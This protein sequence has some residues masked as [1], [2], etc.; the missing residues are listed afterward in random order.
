R[1]R[2]GR[3]EDRLGKKKQMNRL[4]EGNSSRNLEKCA[5]LERCGVRESEGVSVPHD[6]PEVRLGELRLRR[7]QHAQASDPNAV[8]R[9]RGELRREA[10]VDENELL[11]LPRRFDPPRAF[12]RRFEERYL[13]DRGDVRVLPVFVAD[14]RKLR[15]F[16]LFP[17]GSSD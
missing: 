14:G 5:V 2:N 3:P 4:L 17:R 16:E 10:A 9:G 12:L 7:E 1:V 6:A 11:T 13:E 8:A 15:L